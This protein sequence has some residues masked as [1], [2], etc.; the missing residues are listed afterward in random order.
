MTHVP[1][2]AAIVTTNDAVALADAMVSPSVAPTG[3]AFEELPPQGTPHAVS[4]SELAGFPTEGPTCA[5]LTTGDASQAG[6][7]PQSN[8]VSVDLG[9]DTVR[10]NT[11]LDVTV[12][13]IDFVVPALLNC[14]LLDFRFLS[15]E[16][17]E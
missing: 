4:D 2:A 9:G 7:E 16:F 1:A 8:F 6:N 12:L 14:V 11:D 13:R 3:A 17:P 15:E 10:G 5:I